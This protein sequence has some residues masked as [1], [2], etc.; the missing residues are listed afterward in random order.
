MQ[1]TNV[2]IIVPLYNGKSY[3]NKILSQVKLCVEFSKDIEI[4][5]IIYNDYPEDVVEIDTSQYE[6]CVKVVNGNV[7][8]GIHGARVEALKYANGD[9]VVFLDQ[10]DRIEAS[11]VSSQ[12]KNIKGADMVV[13]R[14]IHNKKLFYT[15]SFKFED[16]V[17]NEYIIREHNSI[18]SPGQVMLKRESIPAMWKENILT[19][20]GAD[21]YFLWIIMAVMG[22][23][24]SLNQ[25]VLYE[26][27]MN[28]NNTSENTNK[29]M[30]SEL[31][32]ITLL[33]EN[34]IFSEQDQRIL[35]DKI[36]ILR[37]SHIDY[38]ENY[39]VAYSILNAWMD[40]KRDRGKVFSYLKENGID[41]IAIYGAGDIG[42]CVR[43]VLEE[44]GFEI[45]FYIDRNAE[46]MEGEMPIY[47][48]ENAPM[49]IDAII[50]SVPRIEMILKEKI[51][52]LY[53]VPIYGVSDVIN[54]LN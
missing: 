23:T 10:D 14:A 17:T 54:M 3:L 24:I 15:D 8:L 16:V 41:K 22:K 31:E 36:H 37:R 42:Q 26:H 9:Y 25:D 51:K 43:K 39:K 49:N 46:Y 34:H 44:E 53:D 13:C 29:M 19:E 20:N 47:L 11:Y 2:S 32:M 50:I 18:V 27:I 1:S 21:D 35:Y 48:L 45:L 38:L 40:A 4:E 6:F 12:M 7:N 30:D 28:G 33:L 5:L 52:Q